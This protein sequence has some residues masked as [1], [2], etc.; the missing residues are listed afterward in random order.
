MLTDEALTTAIEAV[1]EVSSTDWK[2]GILLIDD[3]P[4]AWVS[5][6]ALMG[7]QLTGGPQPFFLDRTDGSV[8]SIRQG[9]F[10]RVKEW[11]RVGPPGAAA[12]LSGTAHDPAVTGS[13][14]KYVLRGID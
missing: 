8:V 2:A 6:Q 7:V 13:F 4:G 1:V 10:E 11:M 12:S 14:V 3:P 9:G 5:P